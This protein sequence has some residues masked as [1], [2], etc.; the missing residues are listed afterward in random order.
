M[1]T[2]PMKTLP[3]KTLVNISLIAL[4][5][6]LLPGCDSRPVESLDQAP[7]PAVTGP[8]ANDAT[9]FLEASES[10]LES[11][12]QKNE[13][14]AWV[15]ANFIS[16]DTQKLLA[17]TSEAFTEAQVRRGVEAARF[18]DIAGLDGVTQRKLQILR[19]TTR[20]PA[21]RDTAGTAEQADIGSRL[22]GMYGSGKYCRGDGVCQDL[23]ALEDVMMHSRD[24][25]ELLEAWAGWRTVAVPMKALYQRQIELAN[26]GARELGFD[27]HGSMW[28][29]IYDMPPE[30]FPVETDRLWE[31]VKPLYNA[32]HCHVR[33]K[34]SETYGEALVP[35][36]GLIPAHLTG[37]MWAQDWQHIY[38]LV[39]PEE[40]ADDFDLT[41]RL[42]AR[43][44]DPIRMVKTGEAFFSSLGFEPL[45]ETFWTRSLF[46]QPRDRDVLCHA[47]AWSIDEKDDLRIK[48]C[49][50]IN[51]EDFN[52]IH[53][54]LGH[55]YYQRA[56]KQHSY[57]HR[58]GAN[59][60][61]HEAVGDTI[62]LSITPQY[63]KDI[64]I[65]DEV[66]D[67]SGDIAMLMRRAL[68]G[69]AFLPFGLILDK[70][71]WKAFSGE[72]TESEWNDAWWRLRE[73]Y[74]GIGAPA[75]RPRDAFDPGAKYHVPNN[76]SYSR[77]YIAQILR[78]QFHREMCEISGNEGPVHRCSFFANEEA[79][80]RL[81]A[82]L[83]LGR[84]KPWP[85]AL[86]VLT[87]S[88]EM[89]AT[90][91]LDY[92]APLKTWLDEQNA[93]RQCGW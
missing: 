28:R 44:Y 32:L 33:A 60:G 9:A 47:S 14:M 7:A 66:P 21:P 29:S 83:E 54:E 17:A 5:L 78:F 26:E 13:R 10:E 68:E 59:S 82:M 74:Q 23:S 22:S 6:L 57:L 36:G 18:K 42:Q 4:F 24:P 12:G 79:G 16:E 76:Y 75:E 52:V 89:D 80:Q 51:S 35:P 48:M 90:A 67:A 71:R 81:I 56:Y 69:V 27:D 25:G 37:N 84:S 77:Y 88:R 8:T 93:D 46:E 19:S 87:G 92:F 70:W 86:E 34:L 61:F 63:L 64:G 15:H 49:I 20:V 58:D 2:S 73:D 50:K 41:A 91:I 85:D 62:A 65:L 39:A 55:N 11:L 31:Q 45:P 1:K 30:D 53:H 38:E 43:G 40:S 3:T 72:I